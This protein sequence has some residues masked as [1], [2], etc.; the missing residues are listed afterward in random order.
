MALVNISIFN[1]INKLVV[2]FQIKVI[3]DLGQG[4]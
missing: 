2:Q 1:N 3:L 4:Q